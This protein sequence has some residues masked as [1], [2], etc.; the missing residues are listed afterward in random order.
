[1]ALAAES[2]LPLPVLLS[3]AAASQDQ[4]KD[5]AERG[6]MFAEAVASL[7]KAA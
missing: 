6:D 4:F 3:P 5:Y 7:G 1:V 2:P